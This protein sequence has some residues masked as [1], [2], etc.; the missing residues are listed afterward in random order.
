MEDSAHQ[1]FY[2][3][4]PHGDAIVCPQPLER[5]WVGFVKLLLRQE[6]DLYPPRGRRFIT[7]SSRRWL[8]A[9][10][11]IAIVE[12]WQGLSNADFVTLQKQQPKS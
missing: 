11:W 2:I 12:K 5:V 10:I 4:T 9:L 6:A 7:I 1:R 8:D 3:V